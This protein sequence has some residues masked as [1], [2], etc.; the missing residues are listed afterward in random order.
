VGSEHGGKSQLT[1]STEQIL[2]AAVLDLNTE[3]NRD[4]LGKPRISA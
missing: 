3:S 1:A 2:D 4:L